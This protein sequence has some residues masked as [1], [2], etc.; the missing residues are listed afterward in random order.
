QRVGEF[1]DQCPQ[2]CATG[3]AV[4]R[5]TPLTL[6]SGDVPQLVEGVRFGRDGEFTPDH[7]TVLHPHQPAGVGA[8][9]AVEPV[10]GPPTF[11]GEQRV[12]VPTSGDAAAAFFGQVGEYVSA[13]GH[14]VHVLPHPLDPVPVLCQLTPVRG[15]FDRHL[16]GG[17][18]VSGVF[19]E[20]TGEQVRLGGPMFRP[21]DA[22]EGVLRW[23][24]G[25]GTDEFQLRLVTGTDQ[26][27]LSV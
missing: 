16:G 5:R 1:G 27:S 20:Q 17:G 7:G 13:R 12:R 15:G 8:F 2:R 11:G 19:C 22:Y 26:D 10:L 18:E 21:T 3:A 4:H 9:G 25:L 24:L 6:H 14:G 23:G